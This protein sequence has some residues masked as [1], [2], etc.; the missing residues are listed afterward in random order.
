MVLQKNYTIFVFYSSIGYSRTSLA[1]A[2]FAS[3][4]KNIK[5][6]LGN[7]ALPV[8]FIISSLN[9]L[10]FL[11]LSISFSFSLYASVCLLFGLCTP[12]KFVAFLASL[13]RV[14]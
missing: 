14:G 6:K 1:S 10:F 11:S 4:L 9:V 13:I 12:G 2:S 5:N 8:I 7:T 3:I